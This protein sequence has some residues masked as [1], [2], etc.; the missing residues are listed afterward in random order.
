MELLQLFAVLACGIIS[1]VA[2][3]SFTID[4][5]HDTF[6]KDDVPFRYI[7]G[8]LHYSRVPSYYWKDRLSKMY[9]AGL[10]AVQTYVPWNFHEPTPGVYEFDG[11]RDVAQFIKTAQEVGLVV[12]LRPGPYICAEW[13]MGGLPSWLLTIDPAMALRS[14]DP[15]YLYYVDRWMAVLLSQMKPLLYE[16]GGPIISVQVENEY[17]FYGCDKNYLAHLE[18]LF[19]GLLGSTVV[20]FTTDPP[21]VLKC[22]SLPNSTVYATVD[23]GISSDPVQ[24]FNAQR[25]A[26]PH[27]PLVNSEFYTGWLDFWG[28]PHQTVDSTLFANALDAVLTLNANVNMYMFE[29]GTNFAFW[30]GADT[31]DEFLPEPTS[32]DYNAPLT[33]AGDP[34]EKFMMIRQVIS[35][36]RPVPPYIPP[37][38]PKTAYGQVVMTDYAWLLDSPQLISKNV[39]SQAPLTMEALEQSFGHV[40]YRSTLPPC[41][42]GSTLSLLGLHDRAVVYVGGALQGILLRTK[43]VDSNVSLTVGPL[44]ASTEVVVVVENMGRINFGSMINEVKGVLYGVQL[45]GDPVVGWTS[46]SIPL[47]DTTKI[48][49]QTLGSVRL[50][51]AFFRGYFSAGSVPNDT[52]LSLP[53]W[54]KGQAFVNGFNLGRYWPSAGPQKTL[55][56][57]ANVLKSAPNVNELVLFEI[58]NAPCSP[59]Y[60]SCYAEFV[61][62]PDIG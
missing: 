61:S 55:Y 10:N 15:T 6:L 34:W 25:E 4:Y 42:S 47:N 5:Q 29:G 62:T 35:K 13:D 32:Y 46:Q 43:A 41:P 59:P 8:S 27:G 38:T 2:G 49:F 11:D 51:T 22:G 17:G 33:E 16:N 28:Q 40:M 7:S 52:F 60:T 9:A 19:R 56:V 54:S 45:N 48:P 53:G 37:P 20:L 44:M 3:S 24:S 50:S 36:Y 21:G 14:S 39:T 57:P 58:D 1:T 12:I 26:E 31:S 18:Q 23:F 30:S